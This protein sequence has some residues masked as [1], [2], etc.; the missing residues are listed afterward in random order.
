MLSNVQ[1][2]GIKTGDREAGWYQPVDVVT[3]TFAVVM[4]GVAIPVNSYVMLEYADAFRFHGPKLVGAV[5]W[6]FPWLPFLCAL[7]I[8]AMVYLKR[9]KMPGLSGTFASVVLAVLTI[10][11]G[12]IVFAVVSM[13]VISW[14]NAL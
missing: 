5:R 2:L 6:A 3:C 10:L 13:P 12:L 9:Q 4:F 11:S 8:P 14:L 1:N 7:G